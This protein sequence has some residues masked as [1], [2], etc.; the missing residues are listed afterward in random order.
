M[1]DK[2]TQVSSSQCSQQYKVGLK[3][4]YRIF[5]FVF[6]SNSFE[7]IIIIRNFEITV[8]MADTSNDLE[9]L[10]VSTTATLH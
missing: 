4:I 5:E 1:I 3:R 7:T 10:S 9:S 6:D 2:V 8:K